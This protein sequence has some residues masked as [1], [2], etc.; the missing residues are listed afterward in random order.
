[1]QKS[2]RVVIKIT[3]NKHNGSAFI[4]ASAGKVAKGTDKVGKLSRCCTL[5][6]HIAYKAVPCFG[7]NSSGDCLFQFVT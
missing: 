7:F 1:M 4:A 3:L 6:N 5:G 2:V